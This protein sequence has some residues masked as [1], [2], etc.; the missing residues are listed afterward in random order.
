MQASALMW[1]STA[2][3]I[4]TRTETLTKK[5]AFTMETALAGLT[6]IEAEANYQRHPLATDADALLGLRAELSEL[7][8]M[9]Q[10]MTASP[11]LAKSDQYEHYYLNP[12]AAKDILVA[13]LRDQVDKYRPTGNLYGLVLMVNE[14][15]LNIFCET[16]NAIT[17]VMDFPEWCQIARQSNALLSHDNDKFFQPAAIVQPRFTP[18]SMLHAAPLRNF[19]TQQGSQLATVESLAHD[20]VNVIGKLQA[21]AAKRSDKLTQISN[22]INALKTLSNQVYSLSLSGNTESMATELNEAPLPSNHQYTVMSILL[23]SQPLTFFEDMLAG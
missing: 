1:S 8:T 2:E 23:S 12:Q 16:L 9:G 17:A 7:L 20:K 14:S 4:Q 22:A 19:L 11:Y 3:T 5:V 15:Q 21:L 10:V 6:A 13:K 18:A